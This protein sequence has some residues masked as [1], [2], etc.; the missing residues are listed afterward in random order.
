VGEVLDEF[1][2][3]MEARRRRYQGR[4]RAEARDLYL[5]ALERESIVTVA[6]RSDMIGPRLDALPLPEDIKRLIRHALGWAWKEEEMHAVYI[7]GALLKLGGPFTRLSALAQQLSGAVGGWSSAVTQ[8]VRWRD[9]PL[10]RAWAALLTFAGMLSGKVSR[11]VRGHLEYHSFRDFCAFNVEAER[12]AE[13]AWRRL[14]ELSKELPELPK[15]AAEE[16]LRME[17]EERNHGKIFAALAALLSAEDGLAP[18]QDAAALAAKI[19]EAGEEFLPRALRPTFSAENPLGGGGQVFVEAGAAG[20]DRLARLAATLDRAD[21]PGRLR[22]R[23]Q[24]LG[25]PL[26]ALKVAVKPTFMLGYSRRDPSTYNDPALLSA[27]SRYLRAAGVGEVLALEG[28]NLYG[29]FYENRGVAEVAAYLGFDGDGYRLVDVS[30]EQEPHRYERGLAQYS[31]A[32]SW[33]D[34]DFRI[35]LAKMRSHPIE[36]VYL[37]AANLEGLGAPCDDYLFFERQAHRDAALM[38]TLNDFPPHF[39]LIDAYESAA[40]GLVGVMGCPRPKHPRRFYAGGDAL[41]VDLVAAR[42]MGVDDP[43]RYPLLRSACYWFGDPTPEISVVGDDSKIEG[44]RGPYSS[45]LNA[46][47]SFF[48]GPVFEYGSGRGS[49]FAAPL[50]PKAFPPKGKVSLPLRAA[51]RVVQSLVGLR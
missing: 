19:A 31:V 29:R 15:T 5:M 38:M 43:R 11:A 33:R 28:P 50:D 47:L 20:D 48:A 34:A 35:S 12:S 51:R 30:A 14:V 26:A 6:Y 25:K 32:R 24:A 36:M 22:A 16:F 18:G 2:R 1:V 46:I 23:A 44:W 9:A 4:P 42:H 45:E 10:S 37:T 49:L 17:V 27:L 3:A 40:D 13:L 21:L 7:R 8:H 39:A 41:A